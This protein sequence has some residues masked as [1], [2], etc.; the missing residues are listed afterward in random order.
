MPDVIPVPG[1]FVFG[2]PGNVPKFYAIPAG[3]WLFAE[4]HRTV[5]NAVPEP[6]GGTETF[7]GSV[8]A[9]PAEPMGVWSDS[10]IVTPA[11]LAGINAA[12][13]GLPIAVTYTYSGLGLQNV[14]WFLRLFAVVPF[15]A[16]FV[17][18]S[19]NVGIVRMLT[20]VSERAYQ[21]VYDEITG[22][23][24]LPIAYQINMIGDYPDFLFLSPGRMY[25]GA[26]IL[27]PNMG[28]RVY[29]GVFTTAG[30]DVTPPVPSVRPF[31]DMPA[32]QQGYIPWNGA[33]MKALLLFYKDTAG[34]ASGRIAFSLIG[35]RN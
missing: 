22:V 10:A 31:W 21:P 9:Y 19:P 4:W 20:R 2:G 25:D 15:P 1:N 28:I 26:T 33:E 3:V 24:G 8:S 18:R 14:S 12:A 34:I 23:A 5:T 27:N 30:F 32:D 6:T 13:G 11:Q 35:Y 7:A 17:L 29:K 16:P